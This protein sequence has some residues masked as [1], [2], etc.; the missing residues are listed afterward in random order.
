[1]TE[2]AVAPAFAAI[3]Q[4][5]A[6]AD[7]AS[8]KEQ[9]LIAALAKRYSPDPEADRAALDTAYAEAMAR[10]HAA[11]PEDADIASLYAEAAM[12]TSPWD[13]W[14]RDFTTPH[15]HIAPAIAAVEKVLEA[16]LDHP[17]AIHLYIHLMEPSQMPER[18]EPYADRLA[19]LMP[20]AGHLVHMPAHI[21][22]RIG[23]YIDSLE[24]N[25]DAVIADED[26]LAQV[27]GS[28]V[29][30]YGYYPHNVHFVLVSAQMADDP[31][32][33]LQFAEKLDALIPYQAVVTEPWVQPIKAAPLFAFVQF[34]EPDA[35]LARAAPPEEL[36]YLKGMWH[37]ARGSAFV[38]KGN[39]KAAL[40]EADAIAALQDKDDVKALEE[41]MIRVPAGDVLR[42][43]ELLVRARVDQHAGETMAAA[44]RIKQAIGIEKTLSYTEPPYW[45]YPI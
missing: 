7:R 22:F 43:A 45:Y 12:D 38:L 3:A 31:E 32:T 1:M 39:T 6:L 10:V 37:Y 13:Y 41:G 27:Q 40:K 25:K 23:R 19:P 8:E 9:A 11:Y 36:S 33:V 16:N 28:D 4:A 14:Q 18:A 17:L 30:R 42:I 34:A 44:D 15:P 24:T 20:A 26:Y 21:Y 29:Y 5:Q 2:A 35:I